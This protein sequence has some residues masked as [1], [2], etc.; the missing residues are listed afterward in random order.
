M[1]DIRTLLMKLPQLA[2]KK[3]GE[4]RSARV[5]LVPLAVA[6]CL[7]LA[8][9][10]D[11]EE[12][13]QF[14]T[15]SRR[16]TTPTATM[17]V[18]PPPPPPG[19][20]ETPVSSRPLTDLV[21]SRGAPDSVYLRV[22]KDLLAISAA[23]GAAIDVFAPAPDE[24]IVGSSSSPS[25]DR[26]AV[27]TATRNGT[28]AAIVVDRNGKRLARWDDLG[29]MLRPATGGANPAP[30]TI[31]WSPQGDRLLAGFEPGGVL[32]L[33]IGRDGSPGIA[34]TV[35]EAPWPIVARWSPTGQRIA[36]ISAPG[37][38]RVSGLIVDSPRA[39]STTAGATKKATPGGGKA[40]PSVA[41]PV[42]AL[43]PIA[44]GGERPVL[45][46]AWMSDGQSL[47]FTEASALGGQPANADLWRI[48]ADGQGRKLVASAGSAAPVADVTLI[49][50][51][52]DGRSVAYTVSIPD[53]DGERFHSL[54]VR[55]LA[56][57]VGHQ[58][59]I[60][61]DTAVTDIRW[62]SSG[63]LY[64]TVPQP[65]NARNYQGGEFDVFDIGADGTARLLITGRQQKATPGGTPT[66]P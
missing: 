32:E 47:L 10:T 38:K 6:V 2:K 59:P 56:S 34:L 41:T 54:W 13:R 62:T 15:D 14:A 28:A 7:I 1:G 36:F 51:S 63:L 26:V 53:P 35:D 66:T 55:E 8:G 31:D 24:A 57:G 25:G 18:T 37:G 44:G 30:L 48:G 43:D 64:R 39:G 61:A 19:L 65:L 29:A 49:A 42:A 22:N 50:P 17:V 21:V 33:P 3:I 20:K 45:S 58:I 27:L 23:G 46:F 5:R 60:D 4:G 52:P 9:C 16:S 11:G 40:T 12:N